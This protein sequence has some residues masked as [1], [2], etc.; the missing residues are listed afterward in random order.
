MQERRGRDGLDATDTTLKRTRKR[1]TRP[2]SGVRMFH[3]GSTQDTNVSTTT[4]TTTTQSKL[5]L[6]GRFALVSG[7]RAR[8]DSVR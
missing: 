5:V 4:S 3:C 7:S 2:A 1:W 8:E 6:G